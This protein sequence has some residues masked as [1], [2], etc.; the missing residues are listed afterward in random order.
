[1]S[2]EDNYE[3]LDQQIKQAQEELK[4]VKEEI[5]D[6]EIEQSDSKVEQKGYMDRETYIKKYGSDEGFKDKDQFDRDGSFFKKIEAQ[7]RKIEELIEFNRQAV[8]YGRKADKAGYEKA[9]RDLQ[10]EKINLIKNAD[11]EGVLRVE[12]QTEV[13]K[14]QIKEFEKPILRQPEPVMDSESIAFRE[15]NAEWINGSSLEDKK[16]QAM[17]RAVITYLQETE[18]N[19]SSKDAVARIESELKEKFPNRYPSE[20]KDRPSLVGTS[21]TSSKEGKKSNL[22]NRLTQQQKDFVRKAQEYGSKLTQEEYAK[23]LALTGDLRDE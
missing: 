7:N 17:T 1:M 22:T 9:L 16:M 10:I 19:I 20:Y 21:T 18:P 4:V 15:R 8:E 12:Q 6:V 14:E 3:K 23:Q 5:K 13:V 2:N 11:A